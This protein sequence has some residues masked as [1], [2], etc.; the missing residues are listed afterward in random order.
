MDIRLAVI[1]MAK[2][3]PLDKAHEVMNKR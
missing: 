3:T 1:I 2:N